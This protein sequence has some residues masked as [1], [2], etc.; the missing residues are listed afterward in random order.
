MGNVRSD[1]QGVERRRRR[2]CRSKGGQIGRDGLDKGL[3]EPK[4]IAVARWPDVELVSSP[5]GGSARGFGRV[6][7]RNGPHFVFRNVPPH[8]SV[9]HDVSSH[10]IPSF[11]IPAR[12]AR[13]RSGRP[14]LGQEEGDFQCAGRYG[15]DR[16]RI[17]GHDVTADEEFPGGSRGGARDVAA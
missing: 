17:V 7:S 12:Y 2:G 4:L 16:N 5:S 9:A 14:D 6:R 3:N 8:A 13:R 10:F 15:S 11:I 1:R